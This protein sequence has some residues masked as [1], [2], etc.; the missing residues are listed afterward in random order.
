VHSH[1]RPNWPNGLGLA[2]IHLGALLVF[3]PAFFSWQAVVAAA[4]LAYLTGV[5]GVTLNYHRTLT[6]RSL[7]MIKPL[8]YFTA[9]LGTLAFQGDPIS[10]VGTHRVHHKYSDRRGDPH[11]T[12]LGLTWA[13]ITWLLRR[14]PNSPTAAEQRRMC[15]DLCA[16]PFY[17][18]LEK[19]HVPLQIAL[20]IALFAIGGWPFLVWGSFAR[21]VYTY[22][23]TWL[24][25][26][27]SH[28]AGY[29]TYRTTDRST[30]AWWVA[31]LSW[32]EG[33]H[34]NHHAFPFSA[35]HGMAWWEVDLTW[36]HIR[37]LKFLRLADR[38]LVPTKEMRDRLVLQTRATLN[39][40]RSKVSENTA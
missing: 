21:L 27:A 10:W 30:N 17:V 32:G 34:N 9:F 23:T 29:R 26:S 38:V 37:T 3:V 39:A 12:R 40:S 1:A 7:R 8:E 22:H 11:T 25:N 28:S 16:Q 31:I 2:G 6:H 14:D 35:R 24:V 36:W 20:A 13:Q 15:P 4:V 5:V 18:A 33:W 19:L